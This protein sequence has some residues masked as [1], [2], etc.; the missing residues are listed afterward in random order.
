MYFILDVILAAILGYGLA[1]LHRVGGNY[2]VATVTLLAVAYIIKHANP[3]TWF[4]SRERVADWLI[5]RAQ[6]TPYTHIDGYM[7]R[8]WLFNPYDPATRKTRWAW[9][10]WS[11]RVHHILREDRDQHFHD[12][13]WNARTVILRGW[14]LEA[15]EVE[16][17]A[18]RFNSM[19]EWREAN[20]RPSWRY[21][22]PG[23]TA[24][25]RFNS[26]HRI[27]QVSPG[28]V[29]T[30]FVTGPFLGDWGFKVDGK[31]VPHKCYLHGHKWHSHES[32]AECTRCGAGLP[33]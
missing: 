2:A 18:A 24:A 13:P 23:S 32:G 31:K 8:W 12:H 29:F 22:M 19:E 28:G 10:P 25:I 17:P 5:R 26:F 27:A 16:Q 30:L 20:R 33:T 11:V 4:L 15:R 7:L 6:R 14:Y 21:M 3:V 1:L 9:F